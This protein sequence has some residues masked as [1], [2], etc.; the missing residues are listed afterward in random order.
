MSKPTTE[1]VQQW[2]AR[3]AKGV[4]PKTCATCAHRV[5]KNIGG[6]CAL[7]GQWITMERE[8]Q[9]RCDRDFSGW[10]PRLGFRDRVIF[11]WKG[12]K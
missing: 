6:K 7:S 2:A 3:V 10:A 11:W 4:I 5:G 8:Y 9:F 1:T 12:G